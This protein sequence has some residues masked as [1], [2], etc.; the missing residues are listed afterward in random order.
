MLINRPATSHR[1]TCQ[2]FWSG[3]LKLSYKEG[4]HVA[5]P[6]GPSYDNKSLINM[7]CRMTG[8]RDNASVMGFG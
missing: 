2:D 8:D 7:G 6:Q 4:K 1:D 5:K 3:N